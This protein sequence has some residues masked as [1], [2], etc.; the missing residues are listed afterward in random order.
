MAG[1]KVVSHRYREFDALNNNVNQ[2]QI[3]IIYPLSLY[4]V[5]ETILRLHFS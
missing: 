4:A 5:K 2:N 3:I 1:K